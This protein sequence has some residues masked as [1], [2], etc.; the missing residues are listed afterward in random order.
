M[1]EAKKKQGATVANRLKDCGVKQKY[2]KE[3]KGCGHSWSDEGLLY[4]NKMYDRIEAGRET[5]G[6]DF[7]KLFLEFM[8]K[9]S[10]EG[11][12]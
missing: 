6:A 11:K 4:F 3:N 9:E 10:N 5:Y 7:D 1:L 8:K 2:F 12:H